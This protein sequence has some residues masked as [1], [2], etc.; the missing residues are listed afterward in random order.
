MRGINFTAHDDLILI[1]NSYQPSWFVPQDP[2]KIKPRSIDFLVDGLIARRKVTTIAGSAGSGK[3]LLTCYFFMNQMNDI[4]TVSPCKAVFLTGGDCSEEEIVRRTHKVGRNDGLYIVDLPKKMSCKATN[5]EFMSELREGITRHGIDVII[6]DTIADFH[7]GNLNEAEA[8][9]RTMAAFSNLA[10]ETNAAA[11]AITHL[12]KYGARKRDATIEDVADSR[13]FGSKCDYA[14]IVKSSK[15][16]IGNK[17]IEL[18]PPKIRT[19][20]EDESVFVEV[21]DSDLRLELKNTT[22]PKP[23]PASNTITS[24]Q[25]SVIQKLHK[26]GLPYGKIA[27][28]VNLAKSTVY[29]YL[30]NYSK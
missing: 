1:P 11:V 18:I 9:N 7:Q 14:C 17:V 15:N 27:A 20:K 19:G 26:D 22:K 29:K 8:A 21:V 28:E 24:E 10:I 3:T 23:I 4:A 30:T 16:E 25:I 6:F 13:I 2:L 5:D 12:S